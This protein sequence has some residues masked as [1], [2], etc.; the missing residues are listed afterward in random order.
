M[1][2]PKLVVIGSLNM[3]VVV[4]AERYPIRGETIM[5]NKASFIPGGKGANQAVA[6]C[7]LGADTTMIG[8]V[9]DDAFGEQLLL[10]LK[11]NGVN[12][13]GVK[14]VAGEATGIASIHL[15][16]GDNSIIVVPGANY[17]LEPVDID[18]HEA[19]LE[20]SD[21]VLLQL[22]IPIETVIYAAKKAKSLGKKVILNPAPAM[23]VQDELFQFVDYVTP[24]RSELAK[25]AGIDVRENSLAI[26]MEH[27]LAL[28][29]DH[30]ITT[31]G[32]EGCTYV[33]RG[34][35]EQVY[36]KGY[37]VPVVDTTGAGDCFNAGLAKAIAGGASLD[38][39][40]KYATLVSALA[41]TKFGAQAGMPT[42]EEADNFLA[43]YV[44]E[45]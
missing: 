1:R 34:V 5:G 13:S 22:E 6:G 16:E 40:V 26:A 32:A 19:L 36:V 30:V 43:G 12:T 14:K 35:S 3:D 4:E 33:S 42:E 28:G 37:T 21:L 45:Q 27:M 2:K 31:L 39:A 18:S 10:N 11:N 41:V 23:K 15:A 24:N 20:Q 44:I 38:D 9:G 8:A 25:Y 17:S 7:R 29:A